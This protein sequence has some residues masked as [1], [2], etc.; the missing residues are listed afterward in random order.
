MMPW[1]NKWLRVSR[2]N[3][4]PTSLLPYSVGSVCAI[5]EGR[6]TA[7][8]FL[9]GLI[10]TALVHLAANLFNEYWDD[11][12][13]ADHPEGEYRP[14]F[15]GSKAIQSGLVSP[16]AVHRAA[17]ACLAAAV[18][19][20]LLLSLSLQSVLLMILVL[21]GAFI[22]WAYTAP[23]FSFAYCGLGEISLLIAFG[24]LLVLGGFLLQTGII[25]AWV[26]LLSLT[27]G[28][29]IAAVLIANEFGD[30][31]TDG[32]AGKR[33]LAVR[34]GPRRTFAA[35]RV[36]LVCSYAPPLGGV[37]SGVYP[38]PLLA[39]LAAVPLALTADR[40]LGKAVKNGFGFSASSA[41]TIHLYL[42]FHFLLIGGII[43]S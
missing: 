4:L 1:I 2:C 8:P 23:P 15:G 35:Y 11:R 41:R 33:N 25:T 32:R 40:L 13:L 34:S 24:P 28:F 26:L 31:A 36:C 18:L 37:L 42:A 19:L 7:F 39:V 3:F 27:P 9:L 17:W 29:L 12:F 14:H 38:V 5:P 20:G 43:L 6:F 16:P 10:G 21:A 22:A 30:A